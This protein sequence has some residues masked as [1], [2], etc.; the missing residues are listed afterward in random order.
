MEAAWGNDL[1]AFR[2]AVGEWKDLLLEGVNLFEEHRKCSQ[3]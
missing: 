3:Q 1:E 2:A